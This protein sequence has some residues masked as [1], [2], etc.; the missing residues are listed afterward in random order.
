M[1]WKPLFA[2]LLAAGLLAGCASNVNTPATLPAIDPQPVVESSVPTSVTVNSARELTDA[3]AAGATITLG[4][5]V[6][7]LEPDDNLSTGNSNCWWEAVE[8]G[9]Q[10]V[11]SGV[12][13]LTIQGAGRDATRVQIDPRFAAVMKF[14]NCSNLTLRGFTA[15]HTEQAEGCEGNVIDLGDCQNVLLEDLG[16]FG[17]GNIGVN[18]NQCQGLNIRTCDIYT[19]SNSG[20][21]LNEV[22][23]CK[24]TGCTIRDLGQRYTEAFTAI[25]AYGGDGLTVED[26]KFTGI[27][28]YNLLSIYQDARFSGCTFQNNTLTDVAFSVNSS[29]NQEFT[30]LTFENSQGSD[31]RAWGWMR[32]GAGSMIL[33]G[34][35]NDL[36]DA[37][38]DEL[39][40]SLD[41]AVE[42]PTVSQE[43]VVVTTVDEFLAAIG[44]NKDII[45]DAKELNLS[46]ASN[47]GKNNA[48]DYYFWYDP[49]D[50]PQLNIVNVDNLTIRG[51]VG[52]DANLISAVPR[53]AQVL[54]FQS[55]TN[56][57][58]K[59]LTLGHTEAPG[60]CTG[61]VLDFYYCSNVTVSGTGLFGC[62]TIGVHGESCRNM[63][64]LNNE[65]YDCSIGGVEL[66]A[67]RQV[68]LDGND[69]H[70]IGSNNNGYIGYIYSV[71]TDSDNVTFN[72][73]AVAPGDFVTT[74][75]ST[76]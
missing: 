1:N 51:K 5:G 60:T 23:D 56:V 38:M 29:E 14:E 74:L 49:D 3:I 36:D 52:K 64:I 65:I 69:F 27:H 24:V 39:F 54:S 8:D 47:Y 67:C 71:S 33:D 73:T 62:G 21:N 40:G 42:E 25:C 58:V 26:T 6:L 20:L 76:N 10:L 43:T 19:C 22:K 16:I 30:T 18:A 9:Y 44:P 4:E 37:A 66:I 7:K 46:T 61:G 45:I 41:N 2:G 34:M 12:Q 70:D 32:T 28:A 59:D 17:C 68:D 11:I 48:S 72:G 15:G 55:C 75:D 31:N 50:G 13:D 57:T 35:G 53:Y 63:Q